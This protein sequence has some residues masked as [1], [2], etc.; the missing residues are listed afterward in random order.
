[1]PTELGYAWTQWEVQQRQKIWKYQIKV[2]ELKYL[3]TLKN[4]LEGFNGRR[5]EVE[6][7]ISELRARAVKFSQAEQQKEKK[8]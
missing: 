2:K 6:E 5:D 1:M 3:K 4:T 8:I 7:R